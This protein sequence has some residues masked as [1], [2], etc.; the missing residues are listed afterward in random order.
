MSP[1]T[2]LALLPLATLATLG[3]GA[4]AAHVLDAGQQG[5]ATTPDA[6]NDADP[7]EYTG[8]CTA[9]KC[10]NQQLSC[11]NGLAAIDLTCT[12]RSGGYANTV[13]G[14]TCV[15]AGDCPDDGGRP[16]CI[17]EPLSMIAN[18][19]G[20]D[21]EQTSIFGGSGVVSL[22]V[23]APAGGAASETL[24][25]FFTSAP[26]E[27][28]G[29]T[30]GTCTFDA[31]TY[32]LFP[33][34]GN[35]GP[36]P[37]PG[38]ITVSSGDE[39]VSVLP[40]CDGT[41]PDVQVAG[42]VTD[43]SLLDV[44]WPDTEDNPWGLGPPY[45]ELTAPHPITLSATAALGSAAPLARTA[46]ATLTWTTAGTP[47]ELEQVIVFLDQGQNSL[48]CTFA[49][50]AGTGTVPSDALL[51]LDA[52]PTTYTVYAQHQYPTPENAATPGYGG[53]AIV[54]RA[55]AT[56]RTPGGLAKGQLTL[57]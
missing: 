32:P 56:A 49:T 41:Y 46:D 5:A 15:L 12:P 53:W 34:S 6:G 35:S 57:Q 14:G 54:Y 17:T 8:Y 31:D 1:S 23:D 11:P 36:S 33:E 7:T 16:A 4:C 19:S 21:C 25:A 9:A 13:T 37:N 39:T 22:E 10:A 27:V 38:V 45:T 18:C 42:A 52:G 3:A 48:T 2:R 47:L 26:A 40:A 28:T 51:E 29:P 55:R 30:V 20:S 24:S 43:G 50:S 44:A